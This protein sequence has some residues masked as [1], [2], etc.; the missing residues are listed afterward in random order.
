LRKAIADICVGHG[1]KTDELED[2]ERYPDLRDICGDEVNLR[3]MAILLRLGD[4][5]DMSND[6]ACP[7]LLNA[8]SPIPPDSLAHWTQ[9]RDIKHFAV[10][11][12]LIEITAEC[13]NQSEHRVLQ[14][15]CQWI[16]N[17]V[18]KAATL[19]AHAKR[20][21]EWRPPRAKLAIDTDVADATIKIRPAQNANYVFR[22][23]IF[24]LDPNAIYQ[25]LIYDLY[26]L[27]ETFIRELV[28]NASDANRSQMYLDLYEEG[29]EPPDSPTLVEEDYREKY[30][31]KVSLI[32]KEVINSLSGQPETRHAIVVED[33]GIGMD[34]D[35]IQRY[36]LQVGRSFYTID[37]KKKDI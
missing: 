16:V 11:P 3:F 31:I 26:D 21:E 33:S 13:Q 18:E 6:R 23:W 7:L 32:S 25:R 35:I 22:D 29:I 34:S 9:Y 20:H 27:P 1:L 8:A 30:P 28:Q 4:L 37:F 19:M 17:E 5:L 24:R 12:E 36:F 14:D 15:W 2:K 10:T